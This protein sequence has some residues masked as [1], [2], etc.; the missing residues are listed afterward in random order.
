MR[1]SRIVVTKKRG[2]GFLQEEYLQLSGVFAGKSISD[3]ENV[4]KELMKKIV[5]QFYENDMEMLA[6]L[7]CETNN[8]A[9]RIYA[10]DRQGQKS[11]LFLPRYRLFIIQKQFRRNFD[12]VGGKR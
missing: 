10:A 4:V 7:Y 3:I 1:K 6:Y 9:V 12:G 8:I 2:R 11:N 5:S